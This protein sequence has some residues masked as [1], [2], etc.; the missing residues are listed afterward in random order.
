MLHRRSDIY[1]L[2]I[3]PFIAAVLLYKND[4]LK[5]IAKDCRFFLF[6]NSY[7]AFIFPTPSYLLELKIALCNEFTFIKLS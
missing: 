3:T 2:A 4:S 5:L 7:P 6:K 1:L